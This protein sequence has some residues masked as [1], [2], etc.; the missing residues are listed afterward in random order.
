MR[1][2][3]NNI[4]WKRVQTKT[5]KHIQHSGQIICI[6]HSFYNESIYFYLF[7]YL[8][9]ITVKIKLQMCR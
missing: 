2:L 8:F 7:I 6:L 4:R 3:H 9:L 1:G 5:H